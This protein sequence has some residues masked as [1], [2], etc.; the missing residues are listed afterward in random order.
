M[1]NIEEVNIIAEALQRSIDH[2]YAS[3][4]KAIVGLRIDKVV[5]GENFRIDCES[6][7]KWMLND[8]K[9]FKYAS[10]ELRK[11]GTAQPIG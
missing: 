10:N 3:V 1:K 11:L 9:Q 7:I 5:L 4:K 2:N 8:I 6:R